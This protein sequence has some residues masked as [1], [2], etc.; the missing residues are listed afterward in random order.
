VAGD[1]G[2]ITWDEVAGRAPGRH[3]LFTFE[4]TH[5]AVAAEAILNR[6]RLDPEEVP[7]PADVDPG[8]G[9]AVRIPLG[10]LYDAIGALATEE[11]PWEAVY[12]LGEHQEVVTRLG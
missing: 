2:H 9:I 3:A 5:D 11:A 10:K 8:C 4:T 12:E 1:A 6:L 7:P